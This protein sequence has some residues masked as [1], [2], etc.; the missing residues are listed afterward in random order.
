MKGRCFR[1]RLGFALHGLQLAI[2][3]ERSFRVH[4]LA[5]GG[6]LGVLLLARPPLVWWTVLALTAGFVMVTELV[7]TALETLADHLHPERHPEIGACK[8]IAAGAVLAAAATAVVVGIVF[9]AQ[10]FRGWP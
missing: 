5:G 9:A 8:D 3:R 6:V 4:V 2:S 7:N 1:E 10:W